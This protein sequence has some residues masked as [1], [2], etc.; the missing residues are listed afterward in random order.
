MI[1]IFKFSIS[2]STWF[3]LKKGTS[4]EQLFTFQIFQDFGSVTGPLQLLARTLPV[5]SINILPS[6]VSLSNIIF[7]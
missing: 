3:P 4:A 2:N 1:P 5:L 7:I 6:Y